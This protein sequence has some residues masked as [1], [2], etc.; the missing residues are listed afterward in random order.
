M[1]VNQLTKEIY[2][3]YTSTGKAV[4]VNFREILP[5]LNKGERYSHSIHPYPAKLIPH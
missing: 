2:K 1:D 5:Y 4:S 3:E